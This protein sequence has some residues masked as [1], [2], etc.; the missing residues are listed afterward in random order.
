MLHRKPNLSPRF[1]RSHLVGSIL[2]SCSY[3]GKIFVWRETSTGAGAVNQRQAA[4]EKIKEHTL[5][6]ASGTE[7]TCP[8]N[9]A[10]F[11]T[12]ANLHVLLLTAHSF[13]V[14]QWTPSLGPPMNMAPSSP[15]LAPTERCQFLR[16]RVGG[17]K[18]TTWHEKRLTPCAMNL[19]CRWRNLGRTSVCCSSYRL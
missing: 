3:D 18:L 4:W 1:H 14:H 2:A 15:V 19:S 6:S 12:H 16:S 9:L 11:I 7:K 10:S 8:F 5:H 13:L 17:W